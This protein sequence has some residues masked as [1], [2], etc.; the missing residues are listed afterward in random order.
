M[1]KPNLNNGDF[2]LSAIA[3]AA[4]TMYATYIDEGQDLLCRQDRVDCHTTD[5][6]ARSNCTIAAGI[7]TIVS[8][9]FQV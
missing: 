4:L 5:R 7:V 6:S 8:H 1:I 3:S 9:I 2:I